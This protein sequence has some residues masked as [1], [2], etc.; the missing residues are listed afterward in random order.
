MATSDEARG[1]DPKYFTF[2]FDTLPSGQIEATC[3]TYHLF[4][5]DRSPHGRARVRLGLRHSDLSG[6]GPRAR[7]RTLLRSLLQQLTDEQSGVIVEYA[8]EE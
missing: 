8:R 1:P 4:G 3:S 7:Y 2:R 6:Y 5:G